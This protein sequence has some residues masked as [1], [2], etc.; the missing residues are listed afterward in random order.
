MGRKNDKVPLKGGEVEGR[1]MATSTSSPLLGLRHPTSRFSR[2]GREQIRARN[3]EDENE[4]TSP[5]IKTDS[6][7]VEGNEGYSPYLN[8]SKSSTAQR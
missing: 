8:Q 3:L 6:R 4:N 2:T 5:S 1:K 7:T